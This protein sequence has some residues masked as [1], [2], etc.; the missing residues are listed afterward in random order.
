V[1]AILGSV[2]L[3]GTADDVVAVAAAQARLLGSAEEE[4]QAAIDAVRATLAHP[5]LRRAA[6]STQVWREAPVSLRLEDGTV[7]EGVLDLAYEAEGAW[8]VVDYK[9]EQEDAAAIA[10]LR[11]QV[12]LYV[13]AAREAT[14]SAARG[15]VLFV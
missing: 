4:Q 6:E 9:T 7:A 10:H 3:R 1:H 2:S 14:G 12:G 13:E 15:V 8:V 11:G 5:L